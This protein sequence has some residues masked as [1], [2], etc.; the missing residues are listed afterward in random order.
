MIA[1]FAKAVAQLTDPKL[2]RIIL[3]ALA[4]TVVLYVIVYAAVGWGVHHLL[5]H[6]D[7]FGWHPLTVF[8]EILGG[9]AVFIVT[10]LLFP[11]VATTTLSFMLESVCAAV[12][13]RYY[14]YAG[15]AR[16][17]GI[18]EMS[19]QAVRF[20]G[21]LILINLFALPIYIPLAIFFGLGAVLY[22]IVNGYLLGREYFE[23][24]A[25]RRLDPR[26]ADAL[27]RAYTGRVWLGG[28]VLAFISTVPIL[29]LLAPVIGTAA[30]LHE[31]EALQR[32]QN[33]S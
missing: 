16:R 7:L 20:T 4:A 3:I 1:S 30:M 24:V 27:R 23:L 12:E 26:G 33:V 21:V 29:N 31:F 8:S 22:F 6:I 10:L 18:A 9:A 13:A 32:R 5:Y 14:P 25:M 28:I 17:P 19:W 15:P 2:A 11:A